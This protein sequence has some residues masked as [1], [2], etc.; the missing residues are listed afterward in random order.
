ML[1]NFQMIILD[2][3]V[4]ADSFFLAYFQ[5]FAQCFRVGITIQAIFKI[6]GTA[7]GISRNYFLLSS[8]CCVTHLVGHLK[9]FC[10]SQQ[11]L[12]L[13]RVGKGVLGWG[14]FVLLNFSIESGIF[15]HKIEDEVDQKSPAFPLN[16]LA[17]N[18]ERLELSKE[19]LGHLRTRHGLQNDN[20][21]N[22]HDLENN[23]FIIE[24]NKISVLVAI[25]CN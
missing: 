3:D 23:H 11:S 14:S 2:F 19:V 17:P 5:N 13:R 24:N 10:G 9:I 25:K 22:I 20:M 8:I 21:Y 12:L 16:C 1:V 18:K 15:F 7:S 4:S 6:R